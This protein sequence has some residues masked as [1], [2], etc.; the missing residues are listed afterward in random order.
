MEN[1]HTLLCKKIAQLTKVVY[2]LNCKSE[3]RDLDI[4]MLT[5][6]YEMELD[7][8]AQNFDQKYRQF[9]ETIL[10]KQQSQ[11]Q[12]LQKATL[13]QKTLEQE[14]LQ[15]LKQFEAFKK[16]AVQ[17]VQDQREQTRLKLDQLLQEVETIRRENRQLRQSCDNAVKEAQRKLTEENARLTGIIQ[18]AEAELKQLRGSQGKDKE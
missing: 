10:K 8:V 18:K 7:Q 5:K 1:V 15:Y 3:D 14:K 4:G 2:Q 6:T 13:A 17:K 11:T 12:D 9:T 16:D